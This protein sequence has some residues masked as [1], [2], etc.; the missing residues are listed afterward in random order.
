MRDGSRTRARIETEALR[1]FALKGVDATSVRDIAQAVGVAEGAL[2][3][4]FSGKETLSRSLFLDNYA[5]LARRVLAAARPGAPF[6]DTV[7]AVVDVFCGLF[8]ENR[9]LFSFLLVSQHAHLQEV[10]EAAEENVVEAI[11]HVFAEA[12]KRREIA[13]ED[14][15]QLSAMALGIVAQPAIF[16]IYGRLKGPLSD[17]APV[18]AAAVLALTRPLQ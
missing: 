2:Y 15:D 16:T 9:P 13:T 7:R 12:M 14:A 17:R 4:H 11:R 1:L 5:A 3:R 18:L 10:P 6:G 8:D